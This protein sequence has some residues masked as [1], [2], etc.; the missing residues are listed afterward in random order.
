MSNG[1]GRE[2]GYAAVIALT[3][4]LCANSFNAGQGQMNNPSF[5]RDHWLQA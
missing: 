5:A 4:A 2:Y 1:S 3:I